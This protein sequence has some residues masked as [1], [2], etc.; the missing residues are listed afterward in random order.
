LEI[1]DE[2]ISGWIVPD[3]TDRHDARA[4]SGNIV[5]GIGAASWNEMRFAVA[6]NQDGRFAR[7]P[8]NLSELK[9]ISNKI[10]KE[11]HCLR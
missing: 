8:R 7:D 9:L 3:G 4:K 10:T 2:G 11:N 5:G 1:G 6:Q